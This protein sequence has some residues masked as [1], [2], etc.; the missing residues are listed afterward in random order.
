MYY[1][2]TEKNKPFDLLF[3][4]N[5]ILLNPNILNYPIPSYSNPNSFISFLS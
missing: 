5:L 3:S 4:V 2:L 1:L